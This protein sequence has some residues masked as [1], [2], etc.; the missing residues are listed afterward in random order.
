MHD[1][2]AIR[3][4][5]VMRGAW[6]AVML[7]LAG[8]D[9]VFGLERPLCAGDECLTDLATGETA[10]GEIVV[11]GADVFWTLERADGAIRGCAIDDC[12][13]RSLTTAER[14]PHS[15]VVDG[16][17]ILWASEIV[18]RSVP[19][20]S[21]EA[22]SFDVVEVV[23]RA[24]E[25][26]RVVGTQLYLIQTDRLLRCDY[27][28]AN[29]TCDGLTSLPAPIGDISGPLATDASSRLWG[30]TSDTLYLVDLDLRSFDVSGARAIVANT[31]AVF[32]LDGAMTV[33]AW[34]ATDP[35]GTAGTELDTG[36]IR[37]MAVDERDLYLVDTAGNL[38]QIPVTDLAT[39][40]V[41]ATALPA[42]RSLAIGEDRVFVV[43]DDRVA[44]IPK[45][46]D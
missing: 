4:D 10:A 19:R 3:Y 2:R 25:E 9:R 22:T 6:W 45:P 29:E 1:A 43:A 27:T 20:T 15:L 41:V 21:T 28:S 34:Q 11:D 17:G 5:D 23:L 18:V 42:V 32:V 8:C 30:A 37:A 14:S 44:S 36:A 7:S 31:T 39:S 26:L 46:S 13:P 24:I 12:A 35:T 40:T 38:L 16:D 33:H